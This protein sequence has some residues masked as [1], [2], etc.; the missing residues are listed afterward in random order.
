VIE[1][2]VIEPI[3]TET[4]VKIISEKLRE[5]IDN[6]KKTAKK[7]KASKMVNDDVS[8]KRSAPNA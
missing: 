8:L 3:F 7:Q 2:N 5:V 4:E 6:A 1:D